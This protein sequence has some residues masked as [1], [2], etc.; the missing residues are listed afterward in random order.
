VY[1]KYYDFIFA[2]LHY[3]MQYIVRYS[4]ANHGPYFA[5]LLPLLRQFC[6]TSLLAES[7]LSALQPTQ[8]AWKLLLC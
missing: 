2:V 6:V 1:I 5:N 3:V 7:Q 8:P 4:T